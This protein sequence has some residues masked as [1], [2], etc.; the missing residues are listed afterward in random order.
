MDICSAS[1]K[2]K[3]P[4]FMARK[5]IQVWLPLLFALVM[6]A[7]MYIGYQLRDKTG[8]TGSMGS[9]SSS[10]LPELMKLIRE[11]YVDPVSADSIDQLVSNELLSHLDPHSVWLNRT[12]L[13]E[14]EEEMNESFVSMLARLDRLSESKDDEDEDE[15][16][17]DDDGSHKFLGAAGKAKKSFGKE[18]EESRYPWLDHPDHPGAKKKKDDEK[19]KSSSNK[20]KVD[21]WANQAGKGPGKGT[22]ASFE[23]DIEFMTK[24]IAGGLNKPKSTGQ[25]TVPV[26]A[27]QE[28]RMHDNPND[29]ATLAG[30]KK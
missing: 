7:G 23:Q 28:D 8:N 24:V 12:A 11:K 21:E 25:T 29:W 22:D 4:I 18:V 13:Q 16:D 5:K 27:G 9:R 26:I 19:D 2:C 14:A 6:I 30:I 10:A 20:K 1:N 3:E 17:D 15:D